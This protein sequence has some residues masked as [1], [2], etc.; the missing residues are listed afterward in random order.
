MFV[1][2]AVGMW[3]TFSSLTTGLAPYNEKADDA[4]G[5]A[6][7]G[8][9]FIYYTMYDICLNPLLYLYPSGVLPYRLRAMGMSVLVFSNKLALLFNQF[10]N[11][12]GMDNLGWKYYLVYVGRLLV[13]IA[14]FYFFY[15][16]TRGS[17]LETV[18]EIFDGPGSTALTSEI[19]LKEDVRH[20]E[21]VGAEVGTKEV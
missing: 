1:G 11:P 21:K 6:A 2:G 16:E 9:I 3:F 18:A 13:E 4:D 17:S 12:I 20:E 10:V 8:F 15:P 7:L 14:V 5:R 19:K